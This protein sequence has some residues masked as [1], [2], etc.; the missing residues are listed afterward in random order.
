MS[1]RAPEPTMLNQARRHTSVLFLYYC[2]CCVR[3][4]DFR[5]VFEDREADGCGMVDGRDPYALIVRVLDRN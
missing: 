4:A 3:R 5:G 2:P 1:L